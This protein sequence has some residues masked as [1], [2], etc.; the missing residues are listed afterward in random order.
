MP[1]FKVYMHG[2]HPN[3][4][5]DWDVGRKIRLLDCTFT[6]TSPDSPENLSV[7][8]ELN[9][10]DENE[11]MDIGAIII[12]KEFD[13]FAL[14]VDNPLYLDYDRIWADQVR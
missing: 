3:W 12:S 13:L 2:T 4:P 5:K 1:K 10:S 14:C 11:A 9:A 6:R 8:L 7:E